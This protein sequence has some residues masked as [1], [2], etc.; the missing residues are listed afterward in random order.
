MN[1]ILVR[2]GRSSQEAQIEIYRRC[3]KRRGGLTYKTLW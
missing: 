1:L 2:F 3:Q